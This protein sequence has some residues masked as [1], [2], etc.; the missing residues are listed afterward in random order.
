MRNPWGLTYYSSDWNK[1]DDRWTDALAN[2]VPF[3]I[4]PRTSANDGLFTVPY[5]KIMNEECISSFQIGHLRDSEG[6]TKTWFDEEQV[7]KESGFYYYNLALPDIMA[8]DTSHIYLTVESYY[9][10]YIPQDCWEGSSY[11]MSTIYFSVT[12]DRTGEGWYKYYYEQFHNPML[13]G[14][15]SY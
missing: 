4:D 14:P 9:Q 11:G 15:S 1:D 3:D 12:N 10:Q 13:I 8:S 5:D 6:Y 2:Q 7:S